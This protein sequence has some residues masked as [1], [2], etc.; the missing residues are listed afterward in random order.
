MTKLQEQLIRDLAGRRYSELVVS[1]ENAVACLKDAEPQ[2]RT[3]ALLAC[4]YLWRCTDTPEV[5]EACFELARGDSNER[6]RAYAIGVLGTTFRNKQDI[7]S[8]QFL[9]TLFESP[10]LSE[11]LKSSIYW[12]VREIQQGLSTKDLALQVAGGVKRSIQSHSITHSDVEA[13]KTLTRLSRSDIDWDSASMIDDAFV[14][15]FLPR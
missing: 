8:T 1:Q 12:A 7:K 6:A 14:R 9:A 5:I 13:Q 15:Q 3:A 11:S 10:G 2:I 4:Q